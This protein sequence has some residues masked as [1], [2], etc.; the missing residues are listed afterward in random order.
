MINEAELAAS[1][2]NESESMTDVLYTKN[3]QSVIFTKIYYDTEE[4]NFDSD[5]SDVSKRK[6]FY[7][8]RYNPYM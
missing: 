7:N 4:K 6:E 2:A 3:Y 1:G 5:S 8:N